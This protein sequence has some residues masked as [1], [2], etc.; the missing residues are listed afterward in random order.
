MNDGSV[1][2]DRRKK[3]PII[4]A[5]VLV[6][7]ALAT[8]DLI[9]H[10]LSTQPNGP[11]VYTMYEFYELH[12]YSAPA[13]TMYILED[14]VTESRRITTPGLGWN[15]IGDF[16]VKSDE[17]MS[18]TLV[19]FESFSDFDLHFNGDRM[20]DFPIGQRV[21]F[22]V[23]FQEW[24]VGNSNVTLIEHDYARMLLGDY[25]SA[26]MR[27][28]Y[29]PFGVNITIAGGNLTIGFTSFADVYPLPAN[30]KNIRIPFFARDF[31]LVYPL[32]NGS[33]Y[34]GGSLIGTLGGSG[35]L[36]GL[37]NSSIDLPFRSGQELRI[38]WGPTYAAI[39]LTAPLCIGTIIVT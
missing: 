3:R 5:V 14:K 20:V 25:D 33:L 13:G 30:W 1:V 18:F 37:G 6:L 36:L 10:S 32:G 26:L 15:A 23:T 39:R 31:L 17:R 4:V 2:S 9:W 19:G 7:A 16:A 35:S 8:T 38:P 34:D 22:N 24:R 29:R 28:D 27:G 12:V 11:R 21:R